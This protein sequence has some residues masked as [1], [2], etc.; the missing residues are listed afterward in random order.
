MPLDHCSERVAMHLWLPSQFGILCLCLPLALGWGLCR[1]RA[2]SPRGRQW[3]WL[4]TWLG[5][6]WLPMILGWLHLQHLA[7]V[8]WLPGW[9]HWLEIGLVSAMSWGILAAL[10]RWLPFES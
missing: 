9:W 1:W 6:P 4:A 2:A 7:E 10:S 8:T 3:L 5:A